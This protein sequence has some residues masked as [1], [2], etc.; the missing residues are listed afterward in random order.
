MDQL[1]TAYDSYPLL[2]TQEMLIP[3]PFYSEPLELPVLRRDVFCDGRPLHARRPPHL[4]PVGYL[5]ASYGA[6]TRGLGLGGQRDGPARRCRFARREAA[7][8]A[9]DG[10]RKETLGA[11]PVITIKKKFP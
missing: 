7:V 3:R 9:A 10:W 8:Q 1:P 2:C 11:V 4:R 5:D 6:R